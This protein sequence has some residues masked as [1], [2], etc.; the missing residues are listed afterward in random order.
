MN[1]IQS[2]NY[3]PL[4]IS[5]LSIAI[6]IVVALLL[7]M[8]SKIDNAGAWV[9]FLPHFN[10]IIN[11]STSILLIAGFWFISKGNITYHKNAMIS[12]FVLGSLFLVSYVIY[13]ASTDST[14]FGGE[15][16][17]RTVYFFILIS[18]I[19][20]AAVVVPFVLFAF[21]YALSNKIDKHKKV[22]KFTLPI[23]LYVSVTGV[24]VYLMIRPYYSF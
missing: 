16:W 5:I 18:H 15:G 10:G 11:T 22:V 1:T 23:W 24:I 19:I 17:I 2:K 8:P 9:Y 3:F 12:A 13:H 4:I 14:P 7:F 20:L 6:P 21:Y